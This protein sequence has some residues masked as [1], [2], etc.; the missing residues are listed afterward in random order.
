MPNRNSQPA[1]GSR[2]LTVYAAI[3]R[4]ASTSKPNGRALSP[5]LLTPQSTQSPTSMQCSWELHTPH[6]ATQTQQHMQTWT[7]HK[8]WVITV[9]A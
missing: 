4:L 6:R 7:L 1:P 2:L 9:Q 8:T 5:T 3:P